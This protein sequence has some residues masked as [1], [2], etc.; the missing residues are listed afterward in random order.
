MM[1][2]GGKLGRR[3]L[4]VLGLLGTL[5]AGAS[6]QD[7][8]GPV[9]VPSFRQPEGRTVVQEGEVTLAD[10]AETAVRYKKAFAA[11]PRLVIV[12]F[13]ESWFKDKP[14]AKSDFVF[15]QQEATAFRVLNSHAEPGQPG[16]A[17]V[18]WR[19]E[20]VLAAVQPAV[21][22][23][24]LAVL[25]SRGTPTPEQITA[26]IKG[27]GGTVTVDPAGSTHP[28]LTIDLHHT[29]VTDADLEA[30]HSL[31]QLR[32]LNLGGTA[33]TD[34]G[35]KSLADL[36]LLQVL[37]LSETRV[38]DAGLQYLARLTQLREVSLYHTRVTDAG[39]VS[40]KGLANL[41]DLTLSGSHIT[42]R[43]LVQLTGLKNLRHLYLSQT[44][45]SKTGVQDL[46]KAL[47]KLEI[48]Q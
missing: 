19:A 24:S 12:E 16:Q 27:I 36:G 30:L 38:S 2:R 41:H 14:F 35:L 10:G 13:R 3:I 5:V 17:T 18:K 23:P 9:A 47:P 48:I 4:D 31:G 7:L 44:G 11:P 37:L 25:A 1:R 39:L 43:G 6:C 40:L 28:I 29:G 20:G 33:I 45:S 22:P 8:P 21:A 42:D 34:A 32:T 26:V 46:K 15:L